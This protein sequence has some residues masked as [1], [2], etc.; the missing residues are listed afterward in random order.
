M[1][2]SDSPMPFSAVGYTRPGQGYL[3]FPTSHQNGSARLTRVRL[4]EG[5]STI[6]LATRSNRNFVLRQNNGDSA[7]VIGRL[8]TT[9]EGNYRTSPPI[10][11]VAPDSETEINIT[12]APVPEEGEPAEHVG[13]IVIPIA[14]PPAA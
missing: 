13:V 11:V 12:Y 7:Q 4:P 1:T 10:Q 5:V 2:S 9:T 8:D 14:T 3:G 6:Q